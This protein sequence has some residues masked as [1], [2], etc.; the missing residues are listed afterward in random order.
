MN[1]AEPPAGSRGQFRGLKLRLQQREPRSRWSGGIVS[2]FVVTGLV[3]ILRIKLWLTRMVVRSYIRLGATMYRRSAN[4]LVLRRENEVAVREPDLLVAQRRFQRFVSRVLAAKLSFALV[5]AMLTFSYTNPYT[6]PGFEGYVFEQPRILGAGGFKG[7]QIGPANFGI[8][9]WRN[10]VINIDTRPDTHNEAFDALTRDDLAISLHLSAVLWIKPGHIVQVVNDFGGEDWYARFIRPRLRSLV[11]D[12]VQ[13]RASYELKTQ[14]R[15]IEDEVRA[16][17]QSYLLDTPF[18][19]RDL[20]TTDMAYPKEIAQAVQRKL[21]AR[22]LLEEKDTQV[23]IAR[24]DAEIDVVEAKGR[25]EAQ[26]LLGAT[27]T[28]MYLQHEA[29]EAQ[30]KGAGSPT[31]TTVYVPIGPSGVPLI[32]TPTVAPKP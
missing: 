27:L 21:E 10:K 15:A 2:E 25:S 16:G 17:L 24:R 4:A 30:A 7:A 32:D 6:P 26:R 22:Q 1:G 5:A 29:I 18:M 20:S 11:E 12:A 31:R 8:S 13:R 19:L 23:E 9:F 3:Q 14:W 28:P